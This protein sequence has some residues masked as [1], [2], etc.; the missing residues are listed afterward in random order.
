[1]KEY[2]DEDVTKAAKDCLL[3]M[4]IAAKA[5][6][7]EKAATV[8]YDVIK[9]TYVL[10]KQEDLFERDKDKIIYSLKEAQAVLALGFISDGWTRE[11]VEQ[12]EDKVKKL[13]VI[14]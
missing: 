4:R 14:D 6:N 11:M 12:F 9:R 5:K 13:W 3:A 2:T 7:I 1:M 8:F 10:A